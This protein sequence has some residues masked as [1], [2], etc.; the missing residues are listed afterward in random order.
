M[1]IKKYSWIFWWSHN[2]H[3]HVSLEHVITYLNLTFILVLCFRPHSWPQSYFLKVWLIPS[4]QVNF[5]VNVLCIHAHQRIQLGR[6]IYTFF[7]SFSWLF[8]CMYIC[9]KFYKYTYMYICIYVL[10]MDSHSVAWVMLPI[11]RKKTMHCEIEARWWR[12]PVIHGLMIPQY[13]KGLLAKNHTMQKELA[14]K[15]LTEQGGLSTICAESLTLPP[16]HMWL[17]W[18]KKLFSKIMFCKRTL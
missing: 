9:N 5:D 18:L 12:L 4:G 1:S 3:S 16:I 8:Q 11:T 13:S 14:T 7:F 2:V 10:T 6:Q 15:H 17:A